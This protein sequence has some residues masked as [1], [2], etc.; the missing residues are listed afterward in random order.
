MSDAVDGEDDENREARNDALQRE[1]TLL[2]AQVAEMQRAAARHED[3]TDISL[4]EREELLREAER[5]AHLGTWTWDIESGRVS[6]SN[7][8]YR[9]L[10]FE[11]GAVKPS[12]E[13]F[14]AAVHPADR[15]RAQA[16]SE[17]GI[18]NGVLPLVDCRIIRPDG[19][20]RQTTSSGVY[21]FDG[22]GKPRR[23]VGG[24]LDRTQALESEIKL[25]RALALLEEAQ[26]FAKLG[27]WR[28]DLQ[29]CELE[30]SREFRRIANLPPK[31]VPSVE[32]FLLCVA[33]EDRDFFRA[34]HEATLA[35]P[36]G[37]EIEGRLRLPSGEIRH[38]R[39]KSA[40][41]QGE[42]GRQEMRG[43]MLDVTDQ[44]KMR[45][46]LAHAQ[47]MEAVGRLAGGI[48]HDFNN[49]LTVIAGNLE[50]L[51]Q[52]VGKVQEVTDALS[53]VASAATLTRRLLAFGRK[54]QLALK[55]VNPNAV[56]MSTSALMHRLVGDEVALEIDLA[57]ALPCVNID[58]LE[59]ERALVN[60]VVNARDA[61]PNGGRVR[62]S[63]REHV[64]EGR[65]AV[66]FSVEDNG[67]G[68]R[69][70]DLPH[71]FEPFYTTRADSGGTGL[72]LATVL[73]TAE[74]HGGTVR[75]ASREEGG[76]VFTIVV[77]A[78]P[79]D[80]DAEIDRMQREGNLKSDR[81]LHL[82]VVDDEPVLA[83]VTKRILQA[84]GHTVRVATRPDEA[85]ALWKEVGPS[86]DLVICDVVMTQMRGPQLIAELCACGV[87]PQVLFITG[88]SEEAARSE[89]NHPVLAKPFSGKVL[90]QA[91]REAMEGNSTTH[92]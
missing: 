62:I 56:V 84:H 25:R 15:E 22:E 9:I 40:L 71:I 86:I 81:K 27:S 28:F 12:V 72:G 46:E 34:R 68:I 44:F 79:G 60:L 89:L 64:H 45:E 87:T 83:D 29:S 82:L 11:P 21:L 7:E 1:V 24:V 75:V 74:Q 20:I 36:L 88:Y 69:A 85:I 30:W 58:V 70:E 31:S 19:S 67:L 2:R 57:P 63:T 42:D 52:R 77:P 92:N 37:A 53:A 14:F 18:A 54:A 23:V 6:W 5:V 13:A 51:S 90:I 38:V 80:E 73:G 66:E 8:M 55:R 35:N 39:L 49:L 50:L 41:V 32:Q 48:A 65:R 47:K 76:T 26:S 17:Q 4:A 10:G 16:A 33:E 91:I 43:T 59:I 3:T 78:I 61:M